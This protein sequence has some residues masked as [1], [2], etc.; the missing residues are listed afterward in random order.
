MAQLYQVV[1]TGELKSGA[2]AEQAARDFAAVFK[3]P[4]EK[5]W[6]LVL[7]RSPHVLKRDIDEANAAR[8]RDILD[9]I[10]LEVRVEESGRPAHHADSGDAAIAYVNGNIAEYNRIVAE[11]MPKIQDRVDM[12]MGKL[13]DGKNFDDLMLQY[14]DDNSLKEEPYKTRG[15]RIGPY[16]SSFDLP[17]YLAALY[18]L[19]AE[20]E[21]TDP[22]TTYLGVYIIW[23]EEMLAGPV[24]YEE[25][26]DRYRRK[27]INQRKEYTWS[28]LGQ[29][30]IDEA[31]AA[32]TLKQYPD[33]L[34]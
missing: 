34:F 1:F 5:A 25:V 8:Y 31:K 13:D 4:E 18:T 26:K 17:E 10:G 28:A 27:I 22:V 9:E 3:V 32:G 7:D 29:E 20:G 14:S 15:F 19:K 30:W 23:C 16:S 24:A 12:I 21:Y 2:N 11:A 33:R 6:K